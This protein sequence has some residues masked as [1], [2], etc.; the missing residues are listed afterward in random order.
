MQVDSSADEVTFASDRLRSVL[1]AALVP[2]SWTERI[3]GVVPGIRCHLSR[4]SGDKCASFG[5][6]LRAELTKAFSKSYGRLSYVE[7][8]SCEAHMLIPNGP[9]AFM[10]RIP[11]RVSLIGG[12]L[13]SGSCA[14]V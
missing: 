2:A 10:D 14:S 13:I 1:R 8:L 7:L 12:G 4:H 3:L 6:S 11:R 5:L 9:T